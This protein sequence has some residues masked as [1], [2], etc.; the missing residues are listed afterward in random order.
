MSLL[1][2]ATTTQDGLTQLGEALR[3]ARL[4]SGWDSSDEL[5]TAIG[6]SGRTIRAMETTGRGNTEYLL[7]LLNELCPEAV[8][9]LIARITAVKPSYGSVSEALGDENAD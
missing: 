6:C 2:K 8:D 1:S 9:E 5:G 4:S 3:S 7:R